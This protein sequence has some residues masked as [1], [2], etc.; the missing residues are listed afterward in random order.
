MTGR[1]AKNLVITVNETKDIVV[2]LSLSI[3]KSFE[4]H[5]VNFDRKYE[6]AAGEN[7]ADMGLR[8]LVPSF[9]K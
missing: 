6:P 4:W 1:F 3:N 5:E 2:M 8:G 7:V 9:V